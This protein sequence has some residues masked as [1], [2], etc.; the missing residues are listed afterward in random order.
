MTRTRIVVVGGAA[1]A[2]ALLV[3][4]LAGARTSGSART[5]VN[6]AVTGS[7]SFDGIWTSS[8][9]QKQFQDVINAFNKTY[10]NVKV[11]YKPVGNN[12]PTVLETAVAGGHPP[13]MA[14]I[15]QPGT[16]AQLAKQGKLKPI[17]YAKSTIASNFAPAFGPG[18]MEGHVKV[19]KPVFG[20]AFVDEEI[21]PPTKSA[22]NT[23]AAFGGSENAF[24]TESL[25]PNWSAPLVPP[26][27]FPVSP[28]ICPIFSPPPA[29]SRGVSSP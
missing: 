6:T 9:G 19:L 16:V 14:D 2:T 15:A 3:A 18:V 1:V 21:T 27:T 10:P 28:M 5:H 4:G 20:F 13:D 26:A 7:I 29:I 24:V 25:N 23:I 8:S 17:T 22:S 11:N 12:L